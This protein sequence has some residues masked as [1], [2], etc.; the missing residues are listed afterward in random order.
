MII[1]RPTPL[2]RLFRYMD[3]NGDGTGS[4]DANVDGSVTPV[5][6]KFVPPAGTVYRLEQL[7]IHIRCDRAGFSAET[8]GNLT[9]LTNGMTINTRRQVDDSVVNCICGG[10]PIKT[11]AGWTAVCFDVRIDDFGVGDRFVTARWLSPNLGYPLFMTDEYYL[12]AIVQDDL[13]S[14]TAHTFMV[15][16][17][18]VK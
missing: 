17:V 15:H 9:A 10:Y 13:S 11:N 7:I 3:T 8:Y 16:G 12:S 14:L 6:F 1:G 18:R 2:E 5:L 4:R